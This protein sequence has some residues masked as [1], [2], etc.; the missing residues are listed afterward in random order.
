M[1]KGENK[2]YELQRGRVVEE[3]DEGSIETRE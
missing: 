3:E 1:E 2:Q